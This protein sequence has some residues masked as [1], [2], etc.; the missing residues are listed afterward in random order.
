MKTD[1]LEKIGGS[2]IQHGPFNDRAYLMKL[3]RGD[4]PKITSI[5]NELAV[6]NGYSKVFA[7]IPA[8]AKDW[9]VE[10]GYRVEASIPGFYNGKEDGYFVGYYC[11]KDRLV[12]HAAD[13]VKQVLDVAREKS[14]AGTPHHLPEG[15]EC[16]LAIPADCERMA[17][18][19]AQV[20]SSYPFPIEDPEYLAETME[21]NLIYAGIWRQDTLL[22]L[23]SAEMDREGGNAEMT[24]FAT[25]PDWRGHG[26]ANILLRHLEEEMPARGIRTCFTIARATSFGMNICFAQNG[27]RFSGTLIKNTQISG[28][29][30]SMNVWYKPLP[31]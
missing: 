23:A 18:L 19:Y 4:F 7:K 22:A 1:R 8:Y 15:C 27:Y 6:K 26:L 3:D 2:L 11:H 10:E 16:R 28:G 13:R 20:F 5:L 25:D 12:D 9:F 14:A 30:E 17:E 31:K 29:L 24:D 21:D